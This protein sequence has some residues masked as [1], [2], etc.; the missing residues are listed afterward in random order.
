MDFNN[1]LEDIQPSSTSELREVIT[2][3]IVDNL[4][5][6]RYTQNLPGIHA[7]YDFVTIARNEIPNIETSLDTQKNITEL[8]YSLTDFAPIVLWESWA[9]TLFAKQSEGKDLALDISGVEASEF[10]DIEEADMIA[11]SLDIPLIL[12]GQVFDLSDAIIESDIIVRD[13]GGIY[14]TNIVIEGEIFAAHEQIFFDNL[15][16]NTP[17]Q[18]VYGHHLEELDYEITTTSQQTIRPEWW[19]ADTS[20]QS[21]LEDVALIESMEKPRQEDVALGLNNTDAFYSMYA[22]IRNN[23]SSDTITID[24]DDNETYLTGFQSYGKYVHKLQING[25]GASLANLGINSPVVGGQDF[26]HTME[27]YGVENPVLPIVDY[28][29]YKVTSLS[30][31]DIYAGSSKVLGNSDAGYEIGDRVF[32]GSWQKY[33]QG[34]P[35]SMKEY[36]YHTIVD[37]QE[38]AR[39]LE[40]ELYPKISDTHYLNSPYSD[41]TV[42]LGRTTKV[43]ITEIGV[44]RLY[45]L[46]NHTTFFNANNLTL[47]PNLLMVI[48]NS[49]EVRTMLHMKGI[50]LGVFR[51]LQFKPYDLENPDNN[52]ANLQFLNEDTRTKVYSYSSS[53]NV[54]KHVN[55]GS[56]DPNNKIEIENDKNIHAVFAYNLYNAS[57]T[58]NTGVKR[59]YIKNSDIARF[60]IAS[61]QV[62]FWGS[63]TIEL[64]KSWH[65]HSVVYGFNN[66]EVTK[67]GYYTDN[68][69]LTDTDLF[70]Y[71]DNRLYIHNLKEMRKVAAHL[72]KN[73]TVSLIDT[74]GNELVTGT[75]KKLEYY[76]RENNQSDF[77]YN[78]LWNGPIPKNIDTWLKINRE[79]RYK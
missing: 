77:I 8:V 55:I 35:A 49:Q 16:L 27:G 60:D 28:D 54:Y 44:P 61:E 10:N 23:T 37:L 31:R 71:D 42:K 19:G 22:F 58:G 39:G 17:S 40:I 14:G 13:G 78:I 20:E 64:L 36:S 4:K 72:Y 26:Y 50:S 25:N 73:K 32:L 12:N 59:L 29:A 53:G 46:E 63:N 68:V 45:K 51:N 21:I 69:T 38:T 65:G 24:L 67:T 33:A 6:I 9:D 18:A 30:G 3:Y 48:G 5:Q 7:A 57:V 47:L 43:P 79:V 66:V 62:K 2:D 11:Q 76:D 1:Y 41:H 56:I 74:N 70:S 34:W 75:I 15:I 52:F